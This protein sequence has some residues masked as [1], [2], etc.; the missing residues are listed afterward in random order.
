MLFVAAELEKEALEKA[1]HFSDK[2]QVML[3]IRLIHMRLQIVLGKCRAY[4][5]HIDK[6][7]EPKKMMFVHC[8]VDTSLQILCM[9]SAVHPMTPI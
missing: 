2:K 5:V 3:L 7:P 9:L 1:Q 6:F 8:T 4:P